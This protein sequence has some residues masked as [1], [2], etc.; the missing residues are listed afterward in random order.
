MFNDH[1]LTAW[2]RMCLCLLFRFEGVPCCYDWGRTI[3]RFDSPPH[4]CC[5][6]AACSLC[7]LFW[8]FLL[9]LLCSVACCAC[10][11]C[12]A[13]A[14]FALLL[15]FVCVWCSWLLVGLPCVFLCA[16]VV[17]GAF[18][19]FVLVALCPVGVFFC[20]CLALFAC[21][22]VCASCRGCLLRLCCLCCV[23]LPV[24]LLW[25][26]C[27]LFLLLWFASLWGCLCCRSLA[28]FVV[29]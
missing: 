4:H 25:F 26:R 21:V 19:F 29:A 22:C 9:P 27:C 23:L 17:A 20:V 14:A 16:F 1:L 24:A 10:V 3:A 8:L 12:P 28:R 7:S 6:S 18:L 13:C 15:C 5:L 11:A 2:H